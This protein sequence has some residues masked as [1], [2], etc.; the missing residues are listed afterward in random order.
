MNQEAWQIH[1]ADQMQAAVQHLA[2]TVQYIVN[3]F[4][5][6]GFSREEAVTFADT[7]LASF[8]NWAGKME[9]DDG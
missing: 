8:S 3:V 1:Q 9:Q 2:G 5:K 7:M 4:I 6:M